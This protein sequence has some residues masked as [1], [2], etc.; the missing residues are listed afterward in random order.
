MLSPLILQPR[1]TE[2]NQK[3][4]PRPPSDVCLW[5]A[6][7]LRCTAKADQFSVIHPAQPGAELIQID[8]GIT[9]QVLKIVHENGLYA[10]VFQPGKSNWVV[11]GVVL[12]GCLFRELP[13][14]LLLRPIG[15]QDVFALNAC[16]HDILLSATIFLFP[17][18]LSPRTA[19]IFRIAIEPE[20]AL[21]A[22]VAGCAQRS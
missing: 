10:N 15:S 14:I 5:R 11:W 20:E 17:V 12:P 3:L 4:R 8:S 18:E 6:H 22:K 19:T 1:L 7:I 21:L 16:E 9:G 13:A 2:L